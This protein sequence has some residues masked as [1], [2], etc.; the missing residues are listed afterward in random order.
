MGNSAPFR[1]VPISLD[2]SVV[3]PLA[4]YTAPEL[5]QLVHRRVT[6]GEL[7]LIHAAKQR[8]NGK[9]AEP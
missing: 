2:S 1:T 7:P 4:F 5:E 8:F 9:V 6:V 3:P